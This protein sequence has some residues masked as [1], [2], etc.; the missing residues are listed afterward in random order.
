MNIQSLNMQSQVRFKT[1]VDKLMYK[2][3]ENFS[4]EIEQMFKNKSEESLLFDA[5]Q[6]DE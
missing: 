5:N 4:K 3:V 1:P 2:Q 6:P